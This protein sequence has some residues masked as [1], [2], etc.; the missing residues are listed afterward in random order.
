MKHIEDNFKD[1]HAIIKLESRLQNKWMWNECII[2][3]FI[4]C[5]E[6]SQNEVEC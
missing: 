5:F 6:H 1:C 3:L 4:I 2:P